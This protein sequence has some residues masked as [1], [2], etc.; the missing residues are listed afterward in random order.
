ML[1]SMRSLKSF[2]FVAVTC[3]RIMTADP[4][5]LDETDSIALALNAMAVGGFRH[6][7]VEKDGAPS[8][9][10]TASDLFRYVSPHLV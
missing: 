10:I 1:N 6:V 7:P 8:G 3:D 2:T 5:F 4:Y 9:V